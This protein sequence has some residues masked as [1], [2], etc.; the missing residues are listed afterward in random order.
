[1]KTL[2]SLA[3]PNIIFFA[4]AISANAAV[5][6]LYNANGSN[7]ASQGSLKPAAIQSS[8]LP[9]I[10]SETQVVGG[11]VTLNTAANFAEYSGYS[12][13]NP[14]TSS[15]F[16]TGFTST[17][18]NQATGYSITFTVSL[19]SA[20]TNTSSSNPRAAFSVI[21]ISGNGN[22]GV[23]IGF[24]PT[25]IFAQSANFTTEAQA[26]NFT[27]TSTNTY[28]LT[29]FNNNYSLTSG[30]NSIINGSLQNYSF[31]PLTSNPP[32]GTFNP[33]TTNSFI[34]FGDNTGQESGTFT[35]GSVTLDTTPVPFEFS[36][37]Y[38]LLA[39]FIGMALK[40]W[41]NQARK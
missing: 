10:A 20:T 37:T 33:Y 17:T 9:T 4:G 22:K 30:G 26:A 12:N 14:L 19:D 31:D 16:N 11:G 8:G 5:F 1:M 40:S 23:E 36:P 24:R 29:V 15:Y 2:W 35:L 13:Y 7:P 3:I 32:L 38:G 27:T 41:R 18:L 6:T 25:E 34:F 21:A 28:Q 39:I